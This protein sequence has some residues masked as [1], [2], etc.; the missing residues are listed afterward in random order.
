MA[1]VSSVLSSSSFA[2]PFLILNISSLI[3]MK[4]ENH[5]YLLWKSQLL[6]IL[7]A[8]NLEGFVDGSLVCP[9]D[10]LLDS[11]GK[12]TLERYP[13]YFLWI[14]HDQ[15]VLCWINA[16][17]SAS[18]LA[19]VVSLKTSRDIWLALERRFASLSRSHI[20]Q[21]K[22]QPQT[23]KKGTSSISDYIQKIK[24]IS[25][26][27]ATVLCPVDTEDLIIYTL[28]GLPLKYGP[29]KTSIR[30]RSAPLAIEELHVLL[31]CE[32][33]NLEFT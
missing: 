33:F 30:T 25:D 28:N 15:N 20:I 7:R 14:Q 16:T 29:F 4:L 11:E 8:N 6:P 18:V 9:S 2:S 3:S 26:S 22:T 21:L 32:K 23:I 1:I 13:Q 31:L 12:I 5:N 17:L 19:H 24:H 10:F 27:L